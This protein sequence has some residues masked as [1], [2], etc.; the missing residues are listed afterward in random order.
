MNKENVEILVSVGNE[1]EHILCFKVVMGEFEVI[2]NMYCQYSLP[3][4]RF[5]SQ[6]KGL[7]GHF[8]NAKVLITMD[9]NAKSE[10]WHSDTTDENGMLLEEFMLENN[11]TALNQP[12]NLPL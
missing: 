8:L 6:L 7:L 11:L 2:V 3:L 12:N 1:S 9:A 5:L 4:E 10:L